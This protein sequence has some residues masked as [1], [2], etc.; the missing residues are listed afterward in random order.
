MKLIHQSIC[1]SI[2]SDLFIYAD[3]E[4]FI[5]KI[6]WKPREDDKIPEGFEGTHTYTSLEELFRA[7][8]EK[9]E[10]LFGDDSIYNFKD[11]ENDHEEVLNIEKWYKQNWEPI[12]VSGLNE[13]E[14]R[15]MN[16][17]KK[18]LMKRD[19]KMILN[20]MVFYWN[21]DACEAVYINNR[22]IN[23]KSLAEL[24]K[25]IKNPKKSWLNGTLLN[26]KA[27]LAEDIVD[28]LD[29]ELPDLQKK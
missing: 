7:Y 28:D 24:K 17:L 6:E 1:G 9:A 2:G 27:I 22:G 29:F 15:A 4:K 23:N 10:V 12:D 19:S 20:N 21:D 8:T 26:V 13:D 16:I 18:I 3:F 5:L 25:H 11:T 14:I